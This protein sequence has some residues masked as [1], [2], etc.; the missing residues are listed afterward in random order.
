MARDPVVIILMEAAQRGR[1]LRLAREA[2]AKDETRSAAIL[3]DG[4]DRAD[5]QQTRLDAV[6]VVYGS[7]PQNG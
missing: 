3:A 6:P 2:E 4:A 7:V 5:D 1:E